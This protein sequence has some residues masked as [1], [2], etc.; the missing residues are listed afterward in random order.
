MKPVYAA[1]KPLAVTLMAGLAA[2]TTGF[3]P[4]EPSKP[5]EHAKDDVAIRNNV[6][7]LETGWN[8]KNGELFAKPFAEDADY[9]VINGLHIKGRSAIEQGHQR[10]FDTIYKA[11]SITLSVEGIRYVRHDVAIVHVKNETKTPQGDRFHQSNSL[12]TLVMA[13]TTDDWKTVAFQNTAIEAPENNQPARPLG[14]PAPPI[15]QTGSSY[16]RRL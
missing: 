9:V 16:G 5:D 14:A 2:C 4:K 6:K 3:A 8:Q 10:I 12:I 15:F 1:I 11:T 13:R 7:Q